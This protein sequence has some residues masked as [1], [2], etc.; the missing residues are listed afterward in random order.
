MTASGTLQPG[1]QAL[2][3]DTHAVSSECCISASDLE[4][5]ESCDTGV[6]HGLRSFEK[7]E[8]LAMA[9]VVVCRPTGQTADVSVP[10]HSHQDSSDVL[11]LAQTAIPRTIVQ[12]FGQRKLAGRKRRHR[13]PALGMSQDV[14]LLTEQQHQQMQQ[15]ADTHEPVTSITADEQQHQQMQ[16]QSDLTNEP[17]TSTTADEQQGFDITDELATSTDVAHQ[18]QLE[19]S[20]DFVAEQLLW[21]FSTCYNGRDKELQPCEGKPTSKPLSSWVQHGQLGGAADSMQRDAQQRDAQ[22]PVGPCQQRAGSTQEQECSEG[23]QVQTPASLQQQ[24]GLSRQPAT[25]QQQAQLANHQDTSVQQ[26]HTRQQQDELSLQGGG[27]GQQHEGTQQQPEQQA[28]LSEHPTNPT[29]ESADVLHP[30]GLTQ[31]S[32]EFSHEQMVSPQPPTAAPEA[33]QESQETSQGFQ[34]ASQGFQVAPQDCRVTLQQPEEACQHGSRASHHQ[35][36]L[37]EE[38]SN[39]VVWRRLHEC[40]A[41][42]QRASKLAQLTL[43]LLARM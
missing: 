8:H 21:G 31:E 35:E 32:A 38:D 7:P 40:L 19:P 17:V 20:S 13:R 41:E 36:G 14:L 16:Q 43:T 18:L 4:A 12:G 1:T 28:G 33:S 30:S 39:G 24:M 34:G 37:H 26:S 15:Q 3:L 9:A 2:Q 27:S 22:Q 5:D 6:M 23:Q 42:R 10:S 11:S 29:Q 25:L